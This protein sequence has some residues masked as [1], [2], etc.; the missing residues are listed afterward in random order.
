MATLCK[1]DKIVIRVFFTRD[2]GVRLHAIYGECEMVVGLLPMRVL[3]GDA[4]LY[5]QERVLAW[6]SEHEREMLSAWRR[7]E[8]GQRP[9][10]V[11][12][13]A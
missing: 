5:V 2:L 4:P 3:Q 8:S 9:L 1:M 12:L 6:A 13:A 11:A 10:R 7:Y